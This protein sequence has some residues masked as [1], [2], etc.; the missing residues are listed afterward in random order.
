MHCCGG[1]QPISAPYRCNRFV[2]LHRYSL[3]VHFRLS[4]IGARIVGTYFEDG[5]VRVEGDNRRLR[6]C[7][8]LRTRKQPARAGLEI[9]PAR[10]EHVQESTKQAVDESCTRGILAHRT[11]AQFASRTCRTLPGVHE[12][13]PK[14]L[15]HARCL[16]PRSCTVRLSAMQIFI[17]TLTGRKTQFD[18]ETDNTVRRALGRAGQ[19][20]H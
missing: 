1:R 18:F 10:V 20:L 19:A 6:P 12:Y 4:A 9:H 3:F 5:L 8:C 17:K 14:N 16:G 2:R 15:A 11:V 13:P 7:A